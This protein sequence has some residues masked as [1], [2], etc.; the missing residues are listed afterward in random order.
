MATFSNRLLTIAWIPIASFCVASCSNQPTPTTIYSVQIVKDSVKQ[1][2]ETISVDIS[3]NGPRAWLNYFED[4][5]KFFMASDG[6]IAFQNNDSAKSFIQNTLIKQIRQI[7]LK[8]TNV[9]IDPLT[10]DL[11]SI[12][13]NWQ[14]TIVNSSNVSSAY[15]GYFTSLAEKT[16]SGWRLMNL[17]WSTSK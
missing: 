7:T 4:S 13:A 16:Q 1:L 15:S 2:M 17:H 9:R 11:A 5:P 6:S 10:N 3:S 14:E 8:W 12:G